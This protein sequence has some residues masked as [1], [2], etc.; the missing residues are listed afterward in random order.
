VREKSVDAR[1]AVRRDLAIDSRDSALEIGNASVL[2]FT[3]SA[4]R[5]NH[6]TQFAAAQG[7]N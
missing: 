2:N 7:G 6:D 1:A 5:L 4:C 3:A